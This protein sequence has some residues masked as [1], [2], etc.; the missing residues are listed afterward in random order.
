MRLLYRFWQIFRGLVPP[1]ALMLRDYHL[2]LAMGEGFDW[3]TPE[4]RKR[5]RKLVRTFARL[6]P[7]FI[8][9]AQVLAARADLF[10]SAYLDELRQLHDRVP[11]MSTRR[12]TRHFRN[13]VGRGVDEVFDRFDP[14]S[15]ASASLGQVHRATYAGDAVAVKILKPGIRRTVDMD[16][17][18]LAWV[19]SVTTLFYQS[20]RLNSLITI[21]EQFSRTIYE[22]MDLELEASHARYFWERYAGDDRVVIPAVIEGLSNRDV[23]VLEFLEATKIA[24]VDAVRAVGHDTDLLMKRLVRVFGEQVLRDGVFHA[25]PHPGN[26]FVTERGQICLMDFGL[27]VRISDEVRR[28][29]A[30]GIMAVI[31][32]DYDTL[33]D[34][35]FELRVVGHDVNPLVLRQAAQRLMAISLRDDVSAVRAQRI[36]TEIMEVF[37]EFPLQ[38]PAEL[39]YVAKTMTLV[40]GFGAAFRPDYNMLKDA[41]PVFRE[42]LRP[43]LDRIKTSFADI[44]AD[45]AKSAWELYTDLKFVMERAARE[46]LVIRMYRGD[47]A[48]LQRMIG[49]TVRRLIALVTVFGGG[50]TTAVVYLDTENWWVLIGGAAFTLLGMF[51]LF[52][53]PGTPKRPRIVIPRRDATG[54]PR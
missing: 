27:V 12:I 40:E 52:I 26:I 13:V 35:A 9:L 20:P 17:R 41:M 43:E 8:K 30:E 7:T 38:L 25:D 50:L 4:R 19:F 53:M 34:V 11:P 47:L 49:Y 1:I 37:Y 16:L 31:R 42:L 32:K 14:E 45:E 21:F 18:V 2:S 3:Q 54:S 6:G 24:D 10:P 39:V 48:E 46:E 44:V 5:A 51:I 22:E 36:I 23:L 33:I 29:Y 15:I 28:K